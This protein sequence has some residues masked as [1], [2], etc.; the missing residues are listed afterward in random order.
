M[1]LCE[2]IQRSPASQWN[3]CFLLSEPRKSNLR[4]HGNCYPYYHDCFGLRFQALYLPDATQESA[5]AEKLF[6]TVSPTCVRE[7][8]LPAVFRIALDLG[9][10]WLCNRSS[11]N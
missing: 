5:C 11:G 9:S 10:D 4:D 2:L 1:S 7:R 3:N 6:S 8:D